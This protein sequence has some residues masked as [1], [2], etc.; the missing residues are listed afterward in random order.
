MVLVVETG[1][2]LANANSYADVAFADQY[3]SSHPFYADA[4]ADL[5]TSK[6]AFLLISASA[7]LDAMFN[8]KGNPSS[9]T[10]GLRWPR[11]NV[12]SVDDVL[13]ARN[14][15]PLNL[16]KA[17]CEQA[18]YLSS[19][20]SNPDASVDTGGVTE[21][22]VDVITLKFGDSTSTKAVPKGASR[23]LRGLGGLYGASRVRKVQ[24]DL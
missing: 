11:T 4:W 6:K 16:R 17:T 20:E 9:T 15:I 21:L 23:W 7:D 24:V 2:G 8:W 3:F 19:T 1:V 18:R 22:K 13:I 14:S 10:Q 5:D 12:Y